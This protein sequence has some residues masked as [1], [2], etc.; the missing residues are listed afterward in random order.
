ML[1]RLATALTLTEVAS[2][3]GI[4]WRQAKQLVDAGHLTGMTPQVTGTASPCYASEDLDAFLDTLLAS[5]ATVHA[6]PDGACALPLAV[7]RA[8]CRL[9]DM[10]DLVR[11]GS[12][13]WVGHLAD[14]GGLASILVDVV[15][16]CARLRR[17]ELAGYTRR[18]VE[19]S[20]G[21]PT[22]TVNALIEKGLLGV[23]VQRHPSVPRD[24]LVVARE[25]LDR[26][27][28]QYVRMTEAAKILGIPLPSLPRVLAGRGVEPALSKT[29][30]GATFYQSERIEAHVSVPSGSV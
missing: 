8:Q 29:E 5:A 11:G 6:A 2:R 27:R 13:R 24:I 25:E 21:I 22:R 19:Q 16:V 7:R 1:R 3:L 14:G 12:L 10:V 28:S 18:E 4:D 26:F 20:L 30:F 17:A 9:V 23:T 15:E